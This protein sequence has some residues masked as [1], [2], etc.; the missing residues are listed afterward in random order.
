M[1]TFLD[2]F[3]FMIFLYVL[4]IPLAFAQDENQFIYNSF[5]Q[6]KLHLDGITIIHINGLLQLT[7]ISYQQPDHAFYQ[8]LINFNTTSATL[9]SSLSF[10]TI[11]VIV[12]ALLYL[13]PNVLQNILGWG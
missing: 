5:H 4:D 9:T 2:H 11:F 12:M 13:D 6:A 8:F 3:I 1:A 10:S 7:N